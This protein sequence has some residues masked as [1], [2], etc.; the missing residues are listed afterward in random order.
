ISYTTLLENHIH[1]EDNVIFNF[2]KRALNE[3]ILK[4]IDKEC[5][6]YEEEHYDII[7]ENIDILTYLEKKYI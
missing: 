3:E 4:S 2:A 6:K 1:K 5:N 7:K